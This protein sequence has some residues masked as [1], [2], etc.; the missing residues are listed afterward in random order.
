MERHDFSLKIKSIDDAGQFVGLG[1]V[2][3]NVDLGN[4][5]IDPGAFSRTL[6]AGK[7]FPVLWQHD[8]S[9]PIGHCVVTD[10]RDGIQVNGVLE[11]SDPTAKKA[12]TFM[13]AGIVKGMSIGYDTIQST[14][15]GDIRH[16]S[17]LK[18]WE[19]SVV[20]FPMNE[21]AVISGV[22]SLSDDDRAKHLKAIDE[23]RKA[24]DRHQRG[25]R[26]HLKSM[27]D[28][29]DDDDDDADNNP[30]DDPAMLEGDTG[31][32]DK[33]FLVELQKLAEQAGAL[34]TT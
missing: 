14:F 15:D 26:I 4:D 23:H 9:N 29:L 20:T 17:E 28:G 25:I 11:L 10:G 33:A 27:L 1:A 16:L 22:K 12:H 24:I 31:D 34:S 7:K 6:S 5:V 13:K 18:L 3:N 8:P 2:Y 19:I 32:D 30:A 21:S